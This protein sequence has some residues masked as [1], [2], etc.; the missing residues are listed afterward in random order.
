M[1]K[2]VGITVLAV[3]LLIPGAAL[4]APL[5]P[6]KGKITYKQT[7]SPVYNLRGNGARFW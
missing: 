1:K 3:A 4:A 2:I 6:C 5:N 7:C